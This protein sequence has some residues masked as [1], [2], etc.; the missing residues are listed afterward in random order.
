MSIERSI[1]I[2]IKKE[3][4][5]YD[6]KLIF[7]ANGVEKGTLTRTVRNPHDI[8]A[9]KDHL[10]DG[11][12]RIISGNRD[13]IYQYNLGVGVCFYNKLKPIVDRMIENYIL[14]LADEYDIDICNQDHE[15]EGYEEF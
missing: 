11:D 3:G 7:S 12:C 14:E 1:K 15:Y 13:F 6:T 5:G 4:H 8:F 10:T 2:D 9:H